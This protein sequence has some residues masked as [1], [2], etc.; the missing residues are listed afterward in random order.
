MKKKSAARN[1]EFFFIYGSRRLPFGI[2]GQMSLI[3]CEIHEK[4][5]V[6]S[7]YACSIKDLL[8]YIFFKSW[9]N[10][11]GGISWTIFAGSIFYRSCMIFNV[12]WIRKSKQNH[13]LF[14]RQNNGLCI[15]ELEY[16]GALSSSESPLPD[17]FSFPTNPLRF[18]DQERQRHWWKTQA[19]SYDQVEIAASL[20][21]AT[22]PHDKLIFS[23]FCEL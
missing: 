10:D 22:L 21:R 23:R 5:H 13:S 14:W 16:F 8:E 20:A 11:I 3:Q 12:V 6:Q 19:Q 4:T 15:V 17:P 1:V 9:G 18:G 7:L 2:A